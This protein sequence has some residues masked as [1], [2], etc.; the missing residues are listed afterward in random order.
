MVNTA[1]NSTRGRVSGTALGVHCNAAAEAGQ[2]TDRMALSLLPLHGQY[3]YHIL[4]D[5]A[6]HTQ[7]R[8]NNRLAHD[9]HCNAVD[10]HTTPTLLADLAAARPSSP[11][12]M[13]AFSADCTPRPGR[14][15]ASCNRG[16]PVA[17]PLN[18]CFVGRSSIRS[19][20]WPY[21]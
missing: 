17:Y 14:D 16:A 7:I 13:Q 4:Y 19:R 15:R 18:A 20:S 6:A 2:Y 5:T 3:I 8:Q 21:T 1:V 10:E 9:V 11:D 12:C